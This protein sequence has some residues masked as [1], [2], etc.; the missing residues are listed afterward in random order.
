[1]EESNPNKLLNVTASWSRGIKL[2]NPKH[3]SREQWRILDKYLKGKIHSIGM[4][5]HTYISNMRVM[6]KL[7]NLKELRIN[8]INRCCQPQPL[9]R[10]LLPITKLELATNRKIPLHVCTAVQNIINSCS[11]LRTLTISQVILNED[12]MI[13]IGTHITIE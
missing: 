1:M 2:D 7:T 3:Y 4:G 8:Y 5:W 13:T 11:N 6:G 12:T 9:I 10:D